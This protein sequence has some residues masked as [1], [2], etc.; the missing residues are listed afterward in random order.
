MSYDFISTDTASK[1]GLGPK[2]RGGKSKKQKTDNS[3]ELQK[4]M[5]YLE[6][7]MKVVE[8]KKYRLD[9]IID[10]LKIF[11]V[12][13]SC[14]DRSGVDVTN[15]G[16]VAQKCDMFLDNLNKLGFSVLN[17]ESVMYLE[18][19]LN[20]NCAVTHKIMELSESTCKYKTITQTQLK[21]FLLEQKELGILQECSCCGELFLKVTKDHIYPL[22]KGGIDHPF[23]IQPMCKP[24]N[25][26]KS[27]TVEKK[28]TIEVYYNKDCKVLLPAHQL[29]ML[30]F[31]LK[32]HHS[33]GI[34]YADNPHILTLS[35]LT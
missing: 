22:S 19:V 29:K 31:T 26:R 9:K 21:V 10:Y 6:N 17:K 12:T 2:Q 32:D 23:N 3:Y 33:K 8:V 18:N 25:K 24:C 4:L 28:P 13:L 34:V 1:I 20:L 7:E 14:I 30:G 16:V 5:H 11:N 35:S 15:I 27:N